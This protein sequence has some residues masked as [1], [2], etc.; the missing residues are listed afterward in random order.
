MAPMLL[1]SAPG[2]GLDFSFFLEAREMNGNLPDGSI[3]VLVTFFSARS[4]RY[5]WRVRVAMARNFSDLWAAFSALITL[6]KRKSLNTFDLGKVTPLGMGGPKEGTSLD[7][8]TATLR[9]KAKINE[10]EACQYFS[11][12][13]HE[14]KIH[15]LKDKDALQRK[16]TVIVPQETTHTST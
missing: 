3:G 2:Y 12:S 15:F 9:D 13:Q 6:A 1:S 10:K 16:R 4:F 7:L 11:D 14:N 5:S 8:V